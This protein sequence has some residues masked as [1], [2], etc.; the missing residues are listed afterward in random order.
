MSQDPFSLDFA[1]LR[2]L[3]SVHAHGSFSRAAEVM[4]LSQPT[5]SYTMARLRKAFQDPLFVRQGAG[6]VPTD[7]C[8][9]IVAQV[10]ELTAQF[11][12]L[13]APRSFDPAQASVDITI[14]CNYYERIVI[15]PRVVPRLR[16]A[17]PGIRLHVIPST[18]YGRDQ[19]T[20]S[21]S[22]ILIG[23]I[24]VEDATYFQRALL[25]EDY[26]CVMAP[27]NPL[28]D[29]PFGLKEY[30]AAPQ[31]IVNYGG[32]FRSRFLLVLEARGLIPNVVMQ[33]PSP[34][35][36]PDLVGGT[37]LIAT[38]P[39]RVAHHFGNMVAIRPCPVEAGI[40]IDMNWTAR[41]HRSAPHV[42]LRDQIA[43]VASEIEAEG[44]RGL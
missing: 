40:R 22:D 18:V 11:E 4:G 15:L 17:A 38:V 26:T 19:L 32:S 34:A 14:S 39:T 33:V 10:A 2:T 16:R 21:E 24:G 43:Q 44:R 25:P 9:E 31:V 20:R 7:R 27:D 41:T 42:W 12:T 29:R 28:L 1:A 37:D 36:I 3:R 13:I 6:I 30:V 23:P 35:D 8:D 5:V